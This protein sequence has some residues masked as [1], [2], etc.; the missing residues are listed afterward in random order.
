MP[1]KG[2]PKTTLIL[3]DRDD[4][5]V[6]VCGPNKLKEEVEEV[7]KSMDYRNYFMFV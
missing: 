6:L 1:P 2:N 7:F 3:A 4:S 5:M